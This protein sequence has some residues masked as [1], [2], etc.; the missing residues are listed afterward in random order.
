MH[1]MHNNIIAV[2]LLSAIEIVGSIPYE[3]KTWLFRLKNIVIVVRV[4][5]RYDQCDSCW[6]TYA[7]CGREKILSNLASSQKHN[8]C[9]GHYSVSGI[10]VLLTNASSILVEVSMCLA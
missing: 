7:S 10:S 9:C 8:K 6:I 4:V 3:K 5:F 1:K 2:C